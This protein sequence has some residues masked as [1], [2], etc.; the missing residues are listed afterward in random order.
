MPSPAAALLAASVAAGFGTPVSVRVAGDL[1]HLA[2]GA[3]VGQFLVAAP[4]RREADGT[5]LVVLRPLAFGTLEVPLPGRPEPSRIEVEPTLAPGAPASPVFVPPAPAAP[6]PLAAAVVVALGLAAVGAAALRRR[7][8]ADPLAE[9]EARLRPL[10]AEAAWSEA[11]AAD[12]LARHC[13]TFLAHV[14]G[15]PC[16]AMTTRE[17]TR[18][19]AC[20]VE[21]SVARPFGLALVLADEV[22]YTSTAAPSDDAA[23][24]VRDVLTAAPAL[25]AARGGPR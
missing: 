22:R 13:R 19:M 8:R 18:L 7:R 20:R 6:W 12:S 2:P 11:G 3:A 23:L 10:S 25:A 9:L 21:T 17:L 4:P 5:T 16:G 14:T 15:A 24:L 1:P